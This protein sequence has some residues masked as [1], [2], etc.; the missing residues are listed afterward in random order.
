MRGESEIE[1]D[2]GQ[3]NK[4][5]PA[6]AGKRLEKVRFS[7]PYFESLVEL[8]LYSGDLKGLIVA[9]VEF[10]DVSA[11]EDFPVPDWFGLEITTDKAFK[12][13]QLA[14]QG[15]PVLPSKPTEAPRRSMFEPPMVFDT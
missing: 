3:F 11:A 2:E 8:D 9:E 6:T 13:Q 1:L 10:P 12:N 14:T 7:V 15:R 5:W 4:L